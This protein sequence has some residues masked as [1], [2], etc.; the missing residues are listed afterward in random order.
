MQQLMGICNS[1]SRDAASSSGLQRYPAQKNIQ[2][3][4]PHTLYFLKKN[5]K[6]IT[7]C[8]K[9]VMEFK[10]QYLQIK[11]YRPSG[12]MVY[13]FNSSTWEAEVGRSL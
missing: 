1:T 4:Y 6:I 2:A 10:Y 13:T 8:C 12:M 3:K 5:K 9:N 7:L 11:P